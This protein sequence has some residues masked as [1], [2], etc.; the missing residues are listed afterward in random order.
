MHLDKR[1]QRERIAKLLWD[2]NPIYGYEWEKVAG[3]LKHKFRRI[4]TY[5]V[6][7]NIGDKDR[8]TTFTNHLGAPSVTPIHYE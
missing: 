7:H 6:N 2:A 5:L 8:F 3:Y 4:A 1:N